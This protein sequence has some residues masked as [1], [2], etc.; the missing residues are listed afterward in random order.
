MEY[1]LNAIDKKQDEVIA[2]MHQ[3][4]ASGTAFTLGTETEEYAADVERLVAAKKRLSDMNNRLG[5]SYSSI[6]AQS[7][8]YGANVNKIISDVTRGTQYTCLLYTSRCV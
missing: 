2:N 3:M 6:K 7:A 5:T 1:D 8:E 4:E